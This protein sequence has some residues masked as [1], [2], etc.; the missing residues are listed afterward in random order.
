MR[1]FFV[2][3]I[4]LNI[5]F[6]LLIF[7]FLLS[8][9][10]ERNDQIYKKEEI[11]N[12]SLPNWMENVRV[13]IINFKR[14]RDRNKLDPELEI[15]FE[16]EERDI[17][18]V[19]NRIDRYLKGRGYKF[20]RKYDNRDEGCVIVLEYE[21]EKEGTLVYFHRKLQEKDSKRRVY[22]IVYSLNNKDII[23]NRIS[24]SEGRIRE[25]E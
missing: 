5:L 11:C 15:E 24:K 4:M 17:D 2:I 16:T 8:I 21:S 1:K 9:Y 22:L 12:I 18:S 23:L 13:Q 7:Y 3:S 25:P 19:C 14:D 20:I 6:A 10:I